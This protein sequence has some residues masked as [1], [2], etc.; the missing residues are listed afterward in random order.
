MSIARRKAKLFRIQP[1]SEKLSSHL[2]KK[3]ERERE[4]DYCEWTWSAFQDILV[5]KK[6]KVQK[7]I[8]SMPQI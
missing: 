3:R 6:N 1:H 4:K 8:Y 7:N 5:N 2:K